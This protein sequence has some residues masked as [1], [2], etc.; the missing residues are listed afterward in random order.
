MNMTVAPCVQQQGLMQCA[1]D[2]AAVQ[3]TQT[4]PGAPHQR[5]RTSKRTRG[6]CSVCCPLAQQLR[7]PQ[8]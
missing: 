2:R 1:K 4:G 3:P 7:P 5:R 6:L 8:C